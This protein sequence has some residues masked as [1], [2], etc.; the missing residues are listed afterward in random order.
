MKMSG[1]EMEANKNPS[2]EA[3]EAAMAWA[4]QVR[5]QC[6]FCLRR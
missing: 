4:Q 5:P 1:L 6:G 2:H 3:V